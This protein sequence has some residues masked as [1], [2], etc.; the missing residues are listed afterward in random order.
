[1]VEFLADYSLFLAKSVT[2]VVAIIAVVAGIALV[3]ARSR[4]D[5]KHGDIQVT[6]F[7]DELLDMKEAIEAEILDKDELKA[8]HK[9]EKKKEKEEKKARKKN[10]P[11]VDEPRRK[12]I[13]VVDF[14]GDIKASEVEPLRQEISAILQLAEAEDEIVIRL[15]S[16]GGMVHEY[17]LASSQIERIKRKELSLTIC[18]DRVAA[19]GGYMMACLA[20]K[21]I[22]A[23]FAIVGSIGVIAQ[24]PNFHRLLKKHDVDY[25]VL[26]AGEYKRTLTVFGENTEKGRE[27]FVEELEETHE[28]F[29]NFVHE[30][31]PQVDIDKVATGEIWFGKQALENQLVDELM[32]SDQYLIDAAEEA[33][34]FEIRYEEKKTLQD[35]LSEFT[36]DSGD[37]LVN[38]VW[39]RISQSHFWKR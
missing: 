25:E 18:V 9:E 37:R 4:S 11:K 16:P 39:G 22:A 12:R 27:K 5:G 2:V 26:T 15:E 38:K 21:L 33:D 7:N 1:M 10:P 6:H 13:Y 28:L 8:I 24:L 30:Y 32:T 36:V 3:S 35:K 17:G 14:D 19:S 23:P 20:D 29:K 34:I 31:R